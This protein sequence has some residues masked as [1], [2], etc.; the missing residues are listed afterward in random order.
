V[1]STP[2]GPARTLVQITPAGTPLPGGGWCSPVGHVRDGRLELT[3]KLALLDRAGSIPL[4]CWWRS[5]SW[6][7]RSS[8]RCGPI[9]IGRWDS[10]G[11]WLSGGMTGVHNA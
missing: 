11:R 2:R 4:I 1:A 10:T 5:V 7:S 8:R 6:S 9:G 3:V